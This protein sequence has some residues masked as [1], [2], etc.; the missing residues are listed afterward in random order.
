[1]PTAVDDDREA[2]EALRRRLRAERSALA[3]DEVSAASAAVCAHA[4]A[5]LDGAR[6]IA[7]YS[8]TRGEIDPAPLARQARARGVRLAYPRVASVQPPALAF[9]LVDGPET[10]GPGVFDIPAPPAGA[11]LAGALDVVLVP[12]V[13]FDEEGHRLGY[14]RGFYDRALAQHPGAT[15]VGLCHRFQ[16]LP[17]VPRRAGDEPV[18]F[19]ITPDG[20]RPTGA[21]ERN[22]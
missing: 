1:L 3:T 7:F 2:R 15:R 18:D 19:V 16:L 8:A 4:G 22:P 6:A 10:L 9:H 5:F 20:A 14:G 11:P 21:R 12:G 13:A 17:R